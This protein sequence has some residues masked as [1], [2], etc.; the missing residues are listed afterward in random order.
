MGIQLHSCVDMLI[1]RVSRVKYL[2]SFALP[3]SS[4]KHCPGQPSRPVLLGL[5]LPIFLL[6]FLVLLL[7][8]LG[9]SLGQ[10]PLLLSGLGIS[11]SS[12]SLGGG[13]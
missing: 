10:L 1:G 4:G 5:L 13:Q 11:T 7:V 12:L 2:L 3:M 8:S 6:F 9:L